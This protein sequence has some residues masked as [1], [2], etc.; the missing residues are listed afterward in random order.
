M[1]ARTD[2]ML[3]CFD[4]MA[5]RASRLD[6]G[7]DCTPVLR[8]GMTEDIITG[9]AKIESLQIFPRAAVVAFR[10]RP[11]TAPENG[12]QLFATHVL[13]GSL[14]RAGQRL[15]VTVQMVESRTGRAVWAERY[16]REMRDVFDMQED[17][18][19]CIAQA[20]RISLSPRK[21]APSRASPPR[22]STRK[23]ISSAAGT[24]R[25]ARSGSVRSSSSSRP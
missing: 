24:T 23:T 3:I 11:V 12:R 21:S 17:I 9:L 14:R 13:C 4:M 19:R 22:T 25:A 7:I 8:D 2:A 15:R 5:S 10:D 20:L 6:N 18:A 16:D 1:T